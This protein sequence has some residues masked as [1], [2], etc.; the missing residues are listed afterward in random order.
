MSYE[1]IIFSVL[2]VLAVLIIKKNKQESN[3]SKDIDSIIK[4]D[5]VLKEIDSKIGDLNDEIISSYAEDEVFL[6][7]LELGG[8]FDNDVIQKIKSN[9]FSKM[10]EHINNG[11]VPKYFLDLVKEELV[12]IGTLEEFENE[13]K[14]I[15]Y[16]GY[17]WY[18]TLN[19]YIELGL[20]LGYNTKVYGDDLGKKIHLKEVWKGM[21]VEELIASRG[22][23]DEV[24]DI[25]TDADTH[26]VYIYGSKNHGSYFK[27]RNQ[28]VIELV[29]RMQPRSLGVLYTDS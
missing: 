23:P 2:L 7:N 19:K 13:E 29:N 17:E 24:E 4:N 12:H 8:N 25:I 6:K 11:D 21:T 9:F 16:D 28:S 22:E 26:Q 1:L 27:I 20:E 18:S 10:N 5:P 14:E 15:A 3:K